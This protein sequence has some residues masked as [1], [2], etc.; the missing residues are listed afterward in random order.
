MPLTPL[1]AILP[2]TITIT[3]AA[4]G[5]LA[6]AVAVP[7]A[8]LS[9]DVPSGTI[10]DF[11]SGKF[12]KLSADAAEDD[13]SLD[14]DPLGLALVA[15]DDATYAP[16]TGNPLLIEAWGK[17]A[18]DAER[19]AQHIRAELDLNLRAPLYTGD[20]ALELSYA[21]VLQIN[22]NL[23]RSLTSASLKSVASAG[24]LGK[25]EAFRDRYVDPEA[26]AIVARVTGV[27]AV[28]FEPWAVGT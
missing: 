12:A 24:T 13:V 4:P 9:G 11:G 15:G 3:V 22:F 20:D 28:R 2:V 8:A 21:I 5:A 16:P 27:K 17:L 14:V 1:Y 7:V 18:S 19:T 6:A 23:K 10:L 25:T 26:A